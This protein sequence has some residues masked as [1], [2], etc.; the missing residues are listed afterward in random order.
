MTSTIC[1]VICRP[2][3]LSNATPAEVGTL[4]LSKEDTLFAG[5]ESPGRSVSRDSVSPSRPPD[6]HFS[7]VANAAMVAYTHRIV[8]SLG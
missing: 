2:G 8:A 4:F 1:L 5:K 7:Q 3:G 6:N